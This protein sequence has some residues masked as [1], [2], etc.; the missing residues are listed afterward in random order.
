MS[1]Y[2]AL[3]RGIN[4]GGNN[5]IPMTELKAMC[6]G[7]GFKNVRTYIQSGNVV[8]ESNLTEG[9]VADKMERELD[10]KVGK[11]IHVVVRTSEELESV[12]A[13]NPFRKENPAKT[14]VW[15]FTDP[16][17]GDLLK[18]FIYQ[19][20]EKIKLLYREIYIFYPD[21]FHYVGFHSFLYSNIP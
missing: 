20:P 3:L 1:T 17:P 4:V 16:V 7:I 18:G 13:K 15:F 5:I 10:S 12:L 6:E 19:G 21:G 11:N 14:A 2:I 8:F 9:K